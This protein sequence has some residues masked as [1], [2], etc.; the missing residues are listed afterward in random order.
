MKIGIDA[1]FVLRE[2]RR[3]IG[4]YS[5]HLLTSLIPIASSFE[6]IIYT[7]RKDVH[8]VLSMLPN[9]T[10]KYLRCPFYPLWEQ[11]ILPIT[12]WCD[13]IDLLHTLGNTAPLWLP[14][15]TKCI[16]TLHDVIFLQKGALVPMPKNIYQYLGRA[17][18][19]L[20]VSKIARRSCAVITIS[21]FSKKDILGLI[22]SLTPEKVISIY[23]SCDPNF[24]L[25]KYRQVKWDRR[26][27]LLCLGA[28]DPRKNTQRIVEAY[29]EVLRSSNV[30]DDLVICGYT[31]WEGS[32][33]HRLVKEAGLEH[34][35]RFLSFVSTEELCA[36]YQHAT[37]F[38]YIS[39][40]E[41]F[42]IP[43][44]EAFSAGCPV[45]ASNTSSIPEVG[46]DGAIYVDPLNLSE[47]ARAIQRLCTEPLTRER[48][49]AKAKARASEFDWHH[50]AEKTLAVYKN[51]LLNHS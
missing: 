15:R 8:G 18:R 16:I 49:R 12:V 26:P 34:K 31:N 33:C 3:G 10:V 23:L 24:E 14:A 22:P 46:G 6:F 2:P 39:R 29:I 27:F 28:D 45:I 51:A 32:F 41:G 38:L 5:F 21:D 11:L 4:N 1:R 9:S 47:I 44:L 35:V 48:L 19:A 13:K 17:Y 40:Y 43:M 37:G 30:S 20:I 36:L 25:A 42:G 7:D 50:T